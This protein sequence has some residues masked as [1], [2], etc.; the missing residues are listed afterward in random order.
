MKTY[1]YNLDTVRPARRFICPS[2]GKRE[3]KRYVDNETGGF[4]ADHVGR[5]NREINC[6]FHQPPKP[7][8][9]MDNGQA[10]YKACP[11]SILKSKEIKEVFSTINLSIFDKSLSKHQDNTFVEWLKILFQD[12]LALWLVKRFRIGSAKRWPGAVVFWQIDEL[13]NV[14]TGKVMLYNTTSGKRVKQ[15]YNH[16]GFIVF[17]VYQIMIWNNAFLDCISWLRCPM[18]APL[19]L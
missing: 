11:L 17:C 10:L 3:F 6:G 1:R 7:D 14:R 16:I 13:N 4:I 19:Q 15:P 8:F 18:I 9:R 2:C 5:C 12:E